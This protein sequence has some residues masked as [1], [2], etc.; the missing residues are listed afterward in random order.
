MAEAAERAAQALDQA[1]DAVAGSMRALEAEQAEGADAGE[2][3]AAQL[4]ECADEE[5]QLQARLREAGERVTTAEVAAQ[6]ARDGAA[7]AE[8][9]LTEVAGRLG[10]EAEPAE[11]ALEPEKRVDLEG[12]IE[13]LA[14]RRE[15]LGP[16][17]PLAAQEYEEAVAA[18][19]GARGP[20][21]GPGGRARPS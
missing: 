18:R 6:R 4:R 14:R 10:L 9:T 2:R 12:R 19:R 20:A 1:R 3:T 15:Q 13:R 11:E 5:A 21:Q 7:D 8:R 17:N 16:V